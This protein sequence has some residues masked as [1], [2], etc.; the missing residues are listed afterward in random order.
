MLS[1]GPCICRTPNNTLN[2][3]T[4]VYNTVDSHHG[5]KPYPA[6]KFRFKHWT[7]K[8]WERNLTYYNITYNNKVIR[9][10]HPL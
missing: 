3:W 7:D 6:Y 10:M 8:L 2:K 9:A 5:T 1:P 4:Q